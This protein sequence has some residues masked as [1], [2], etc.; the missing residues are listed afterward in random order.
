MEYLGEYVFEELT[1]GLLDDLVILGV[2]PLV[3][4]LHK[5]LAVPVLLDGLE[6][7]PYQLVVGAVQFLQVWVVL[8]GVGIAFGADVPG[9][10]TKCD[11]S[12]TSCPAKL[13]HQCPWLLPG[14]C[15]HIC[16]GTNL[17]SAHTRCRTA[18]HRRVAGT[19]SRSRRS[20]WHSGT[21]RKRTC[22][23]SSETSDIEK[24]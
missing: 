23:Q 21:R 13:T 1:H 10:K 18:I 16:H 12:H 22:K 19:G 3:H 5:L 8:F 7:F 2:L 9:K 4:G 15:Q 14:G 24:Q 6:R 17:S 20:L 11:T